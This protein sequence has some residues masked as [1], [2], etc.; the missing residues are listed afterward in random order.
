MRKNYIV[1]RYR[2]FTNNCTQ[3]CQGQEDHIKHIAFY[4]SYQ[5]TITNFV[6]F[7]CPKIRLKS[8]CKTIT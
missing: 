7:I 1:Y 5:P 6:L 8:W 3:L 4:A 2:Y